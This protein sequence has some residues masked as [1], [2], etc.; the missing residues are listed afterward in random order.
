MQNHPSL[1]GGK[2]NKNKTPGICCRLQ[3]LVPQLS[4]SI[5][6]KTN[7]QKIDFCPTLNYSTD[8]LTRSFNIFFIQQLQ[9]EIETHNAWSEEASLKLENALKNKKVRET[10]L[11]I[12]VGQCNSHYV[13]KYFSF[14][15]TT[16]KDKGQWKKVTQVLPYCS[17]LL[18]CSES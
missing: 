3:H 17:T 8:L 14:R 5:L 12:N 10:V 16:K 7:V 9:R 15:T 11:I 4:C 1:H 13:I 18:G 2:Q 6:L